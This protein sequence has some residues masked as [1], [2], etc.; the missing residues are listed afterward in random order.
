MT[1][2]MDLLFLTNFTTNHLTTA[3]VMVI[4]A[5]IITAVSKN[6]GS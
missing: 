4:I 1:L 5:K 3:P 2:E 6:L